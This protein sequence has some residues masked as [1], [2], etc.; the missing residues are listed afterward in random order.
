MNLIVK[1]SSAKYILKRDTGYFNQ[2]T[3]W[4]V[5]KLVHTSG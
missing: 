2:L 5:I 1:Q 4:Y 3:N